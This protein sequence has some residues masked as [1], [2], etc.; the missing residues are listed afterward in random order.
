MLRFVAALL[1]ATSTSISM[2]SP[3]VQDDVA[4]PALSR[5][6]YGPDYRVLAAALDNGSLTLPRF[7]SGPDAALLRRL[8]AVENLTLQR[9]R[10][11]PIESRLQ[12][13]LAMQQA[14]G[15]VLN[16]YLQAANRGEPV[17]AELAALLSFMLH[18]SASSANMV[19]EYL[20]TIPKD[21]KYQVRMQ[22]LAKVKEGLTTVFLGA[23]TTLS[24]TRFYTP[25]DLSQV[26]AAMAASLPSV[27][28]LFAPDFRAELRRKLA[29]RRNAAKKP[30]D[31]ANLDKMLAELEK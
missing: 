30:E 1:L 19:D 4:L 18:L 10:T 15:T 29:A 20:P 11:L 9:N 5:Q 7:S 21:E 24:E 8:T 25:E 26:M 14:I 22:G 27:D 3:A 23:E 16:H 13:F 28:K 12:D 17:H 2:A 31:I 6:W